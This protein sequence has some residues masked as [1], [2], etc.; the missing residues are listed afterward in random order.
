MK[1]IMDGN[2]AC[3]LV[4]YNFI[5]AAGIYPITPASTMAENVSVFSNNNKLNYNNSKVKV[6]EMQSEA[7]AIAAVHGMLQNGILASTYTASQGLLLMLPNMY[8]IAGEML[9]CVIN[10]AARTIATHS[11]SIMGDHSDIYSCRGTGFAMF[12]TSSVQQ[13][14]DLT[15]VPYLSSIKS[16]IPFINF[17]DGFRTSHEYNKIDVIDYSKVKDLIDKKELKKFRDSALDIDNPTTRGTNQTDSTYFQISESR[18]N[19]YNKLPDIVNDYMKEISLITGRKYAPFTYYGSGTATNVVVAMGSVC[20]AI[21]EYIDI[22]KDKKIGLIEVHL[23]RPFSSKYLLKV[24][25][26]TVKNIAVLDRVKEPGSYREPLFLDVA[27]VINGVNKKINLFAGRYGLSSK[28]TNLNDIDALYK[29][30]DKKIKRDIFTLG[31][32]DDLTDLSLD[33]TNTIFKSLSDEVLIWGYGSDGMV[34]ASKDIITIVG[35]STE[36]Y[37]QGY[38]EYDSKKS[39]G[40]TKSHLRIGDKPISSTYYVTSPKYVVLTKESYL[41]KYDVLEG[42]KD[43][44][45]FLL[46]T[47]KK[48]DELDIPSE[49]LEIIKNK[50]IKFYI[51]DASKIASDNHIPNKISMIMEMAIFKVFKL[52]DKDVYS[53]EIEKLINKNFLK[54][55]KEIVNNNINAIKEV[56]NSI[57]KVDL[58]KLISN[59]NKYETKDVFEYLDHLKGNEL[60]VKAL[61][62]YKTGIFEKGLSKLEK[63]GVSDITPSYDKEKC[64]MCNM[65]SFVCPHSVI[66]PYLL[67]EDEYKKAPSFVKESCK[68]AGFKDKKLYFTICSSPLDCTS[69]KLCEGICPTKAITMKIKNELEV[70]RF[71]YLE[72]LEEKRPLPTNTI[73]GSQFVKP[74]FMYPGAC[75]GCGETPYLKLLSQ[76]FKDNLMVANATGCSSIYGAS[77]PSTPWEVPWINSLFEDNAEFGYGI[78]LAEDFGKNKVKEIM[79]SCYKKLSSKNKKLVKEY[80]DNYS[81]EVSFKVYESLDYKD[82]KEIVPY[83]KY[84]KE[85]SIWLVGGDGW[86]YD[87]GFGG[88]DHVLCSK[89]NVNILVLDTEVYSN[90]GGQASK[91]TRCGAVAKFCEAGKETNKKNLAKI[92]MAYDNAY[93]GTISLGANPKQ[94]IDTLMEAESFDGPSIVIA[95]SPCI[96]HGIKSGM[97]TSYKEEKLATDSGYFP[98]FRYNPKTKE[99]KTDSKSNYEKLDDLFNNEVRF[100]SNKELI[101]KS[102][103]YIKDNNIKA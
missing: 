12:A 48:E 82:F 64:I 95:Y 26:K 49:V 45:V 10:V 40:V 77:V 101:E 81:K 80:L 93:V 98:L 2:K 88:I 34:T 4:S 43:G 1:E 71:N 102:K 72:K 92:A 28:D 35:S 23:Y 73:K 97:G 41:Y 5:D 69:C 52:I 20:S 9:P 61:E 65:C 29:F 87:I 68:D 70:K 85:K 42:I 39:G 100:N 55:G 96:A 36:K 56:E 60:S 16:H 30:L 37:V 90:T 14:M 76:I 24:L 94:A 103:D 99:L 33:K 25:P 78:R 91:S 84:I 51:I 74:S 89:E 22:T 19:D 62:K 53:K 18:N 3:A 50:N 7:G 17:F 54:K 75:A 6:V 8:K 83:K 63:R 59:T 11:L 38:F 86:A 21:R 13:V 44:G 32:N 66:R 79:S 31:I 27:G 47:S 57:T 67:T 58:N 46:N 15:A